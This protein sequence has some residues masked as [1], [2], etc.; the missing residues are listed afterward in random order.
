MIPAAWR[1]AAGIPHGKLECAAETVGDAVEWLVTAH[2]ELEPR[3][4]AE[5]GRLVSWVS[6]Y[7]GAD[8]IRDLD[9]LNTTVP[10]ESE[11]VVLPAL[12]GG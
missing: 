8:D 10:P 2:P 5:P 4:L 6:L 9:G 11:I 1:T 7:L 3:V 12:A